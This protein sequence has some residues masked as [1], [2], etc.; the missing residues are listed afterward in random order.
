MTRKSVGIHMEG[1]SDNTVHGNTIIG[2]DIGIKS[3]NETRASITGNTVSKE[4]EA[5]NFL[6]A[7]IDAAPMTEQQRLDAAEIF[8]EIQEKAQAEKPKISIIKT[9]V[10]GLPKVDGIIQAGQNLLSLFEKLL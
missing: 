3:V 7:Q 9:L 10:E 8:N 2:Y 1:G 5:L 6:R 4:Q